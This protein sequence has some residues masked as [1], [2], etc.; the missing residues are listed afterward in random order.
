MDLNEYRAYYINSMESQALAS[1]IYPVDAF[2]DDAIDMMINDWSLI[3]QE[4]EPCYCNEKSQSRLFKSMHIDAANVDTLTNTLNLLIADYNSKENVPV[5]NE[6]IRNS[7][8]LMLSYFENTLKGY[9][10]TTEPSAPYTQ[11]AVNI[12][13]NLGLISKIHLY[14]ISTNTL[15]EK[16]AKTFDLPP[17]IFEGKSYSVDVNVIDFNIIYKSKA[18]LIGKEPINIVTSEFGNNGIPCIKA[19][20]EA[21]DYQS[22]LA[23][24]PGKFLADIYDKYETRLLESNVRCFLSFRGAINKGIRGTIL[25]AKDKFFTYNNGISATAKSIVLDKDNRKIIEFKDLQIV[26]GGQTTASL[27]SVRIKDKADLSGIYVQMKLTVVPDDNPDLIRNIS[28]F[29]NSQNKVTNADLNS[30]HQFY[31]VIEGFSRKIF[32]PPAPG[33]QYQEMW[34]FERTRGQYEQPMMALTKAKRDQYILERPKNKKFTK[35]DL[36]KYYN[37]A[38][39]LPY[40]VSWGADVNAV[41]F[42]EIIEKEWEKNRDQ[43]NEYFYKELIGMAIMFKHL[44]KLVSDQE[45]Y[46]EDKAYR[47]QIVTYTF[48]KFVYC[49]LK[50]NKFINYKAIWDAQAVPAQFDDDLSRIAKRVYDVIIKHAVGNV[51]SYCKQKTTW[52]MFAREPMDL[53]KETISLLIS[54][55]DKEVSSRMAEKSQKETNKIKDIMAIFNKGVDYW[56]KTKSLGIEQHV[57]TPYEEDLMDRIIN[58]IKVGKLIQDRQSLKDIDVMINKLIENG[59]IQD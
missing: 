7:A 24:V 59:I 19:D 31:N 3:S 1:T 12:L 38:N 34:F 8:Q 50:N 57:L 20:I 28:K 48:S 6:F 43:F 25:N 22:Y 58:M 5:N 35:M 54:K 51:T 44:E 56:Q 53:S 26:N 40:F 15:S 14:I 10:R 29:A 41:R 18:Q 49:A 46:Q 9:F 55:E 21:S 11:M 36:A 23:I 16:A 45:W 13:R 42:Y 17:F 47:P 52:E 2:I 4:L 33:Q 27:S 32:A 30:N 39:M 37:S